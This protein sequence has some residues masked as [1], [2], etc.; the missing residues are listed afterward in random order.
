MPISGRTALERHGGA[1]E[2]CLI[3]VRAL[4]CTPA[5]HSKRHGNGF[6]SSLAPWPLALLQGAGNI[7]SSNVSDVVNKCAAPDSLLFLLRTNKHAHDAP[8]PP[9]AVELTTARPDTPLSRVLLEGCVAVLKLNPVNEYTGPT[10]E[11][12]LAPLIAR[13][14]LKVVYG[15]GAVRIPEP[16]QPRQ[17]LASRSSGTPRSVF[18]S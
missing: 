4:S 14:V 9:L 3:L 17:N 8:F 18:R 6:V 5:V 12:A 16:Q 13:G 10:I 1:G 15:G 11:R 2:C 7:P